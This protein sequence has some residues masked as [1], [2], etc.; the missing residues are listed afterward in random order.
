MTII[1][2]TLADCWDMGRKDL[3][4][5]TKSGTARLPFSLSQNP[6]FPLTRHRRKEAIQQGA[7]VR[8]YL[9]SLFLHT[10]ALAVNPLGRTTTEPLLLIRCKALNRWIEGLSGAKKRR[11]RSRGV[12]DLGFSQKRNFDATKKLAAPGF[13]E[14]VWSGQLPAKRVNASQDDQ[15]LPLNST[16]RQ[17][18]NK[19]IN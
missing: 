1:D 12:H 2:S 15:T 4:T 10:P 6:P 9:A 16:A 19:L 5:K 17:A 7:S 18:A 8:D 11:C 3:K 14:E 13:R